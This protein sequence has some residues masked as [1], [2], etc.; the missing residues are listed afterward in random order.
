MM[1]KI[2]KPIIVGI[3]SEDTYNDLMK[4]W[5][6]EHRFYH[7]LNHLEHMLTEIEALYN[8]KEIDENERIIL[9]TIA[10]FHDVI[11]DPKSKTNEEDSVSYFNTC[12]IKR[13]LSN[14]EEINKRK[15]FV[16]QVKLSIMATKENTPPSDKLSNLIWSIDN[17]IFAY[18]F[19]TLIEYEHE[20]YKE[21]QFVDYETYRMERVKFLQT[22]IGIF[23]EIVD[24]NIEQLMEYVAHR[25]P[26]IAI[27][28][29]SFNPFHIGH[30]D[31]LKR[32]E[33]M[34]DK[35]IIGFGTNPDKEKRD[36]EIP[37]KIANRE[38]VVYS[39][40]ITELIT[41]QES[42]NQN[43]TLIRG[44]RNASDLLYEQNMISFI[45]DIK[46]DVNVIYIPCDKK[47]EHVSSSSINVLKKYN[48]QKIN[49]YLI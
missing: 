33:R 23:S 1:Y 20:I 14:Q 40:L 38:C 46:S 45:K 28:A 36:V 6:E 39:G 49:D 16:E 27:F 11:Y 22:R 25:K 48:N 32:A 34:F 26:N 7:N 29:G 17:S 8:K 18:A 21:F 13:W 4:K 42:M 24:K 12:F 9:I 30:Y 44:L 10:F 31:I 3:F 37:A 5:N 47:Y 43:V 19:S 2:L 41:S 15:G 35:V